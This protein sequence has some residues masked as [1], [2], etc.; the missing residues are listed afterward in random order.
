MNDLLHLAAADLCAWL[1]RVLPTLGPDWWTRYVFEQLTFAQQ[2]TATERRISRLEE[3]D[4]AAMLRVF[5]QNWYD[6]SSRENLPRDARN[7]LKELQ[8]VRNRVAHAPSA[9]FAPGDLYRD[10]DTLARVLQ[11]IGA[12][13][14]S[15]N[16]VEE[17]RAEVA[18]RL[19]P[20]HAGAL[21]GAPSSV[22]TTQVQ[23][24][25]GAAAT[26]AVAPATQ[27]SA[28]QMVSLRSD[29]TVIVPVLEVIPG[30]PNRYRV[31]EGQ[32]R[33]TYYEAQLVAVNED[34]PDHKPFTAAELSTLLTSMQLSSPTA[35]ALY[36]L[37]A[38]R[39]RFV[40]YQY[41]PVFKLIRA[42]RPR[43][44][45][46]DEVGVGKTIEAGLML[47]ELQ[48]R[49][50]I[51]SVLIICPKAL[52][53]E[54]KWEL[55]MKR[56][57]EHFTP[58]DSV[59]F[60]HCIDETHRDGAWPLQYERAILPF[61]LIDAET[62]LGDGRRR[63]G[64]TQLEEPPR[65]D[66]VIVDEAHHIR[67]SET[68]LHQAVRFFADNAEAVIFL[69][70]T[71][72]QLGRSDL[73]TVLNVLRP[74]LIIDPASFEQ[75]AAPNPHINAG[76]LACRRAGPDWA[77][78]VRQ[79]LLAVVATT[80]GRDVLAVNPGFQQIYDAL[81]GPEG[82]ALSR[83]KAIH[84]LEEL[85]T[86][87]A[88]INRTRRRDIGEFTTRKPETVSRD[89]TPTQQQLHD[90]LLSVIARILN[91]LHGSQNV[92]F[93]MTTI[94][95]QAASSLYGLAPALEDMLSGKLD[96]LETEIALDDEIDSIDADELASIR[97]DIQGLIRQA[98]A[99]DP[100][101]PKAD[102]FTMI[103]GEKLQMPKNKVL[104]FSTFR[105]TL[106]YLSRKLEDAGVRYALVQ[107]DIDD[108]ERSERRRRF[109]LPKVDP[110]AI[111]VLLSSE[112]GCEG[113]DFQF[114]D[115]LINYD[116]PW[117]PMRIEQRIGRIDRYGQ[118]SESIRIY[119][120]IT[121]GTIDADIYNRCLLRI[122]VFHAALGG[123]EEILGAV[124]QDLSKVA[125]SYALNEP[126]RQE[127]LQ[128]LADNH[129]R[130]L[131]EE[132][133]LDE[134]QGELFGLN[135]EAASW[136]EKLSAA[137]SYWLEPPAI[138]A[139][140]SSYL[141]KR[142]G[143]GQEYL[144]GEK[145]LKTLR[146]NQEARSALLEDFRRLPKT[147]DPNSRLWERWLRGAA[148]MLSVSFDQDMAIDHPEAM[149]VT[150]HHPLVRQAAGYLSESSTVSVQLCAL[151]ERIAPGAYP[152]AVYRW[153]KLGV[154]ADEELVP[155]TLDPMVTEGLFELLQSS[156]DAP[157]LRVISA[158]A[159]D[160]L[161]AAHH[162]RWLE[163]TAS[164]AEENRQLVNARRQSLQASHQAREA[165]LTDQLNNATNE[166]I[167][168]MKE[169][170]RSRMRADYA[171]RL[172]TLERAAE[173]GDIRA[174]LVVVGVIKVK[175]GSSAS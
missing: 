45:V 167:R 86:F 94:S 37:N 53:A 121:P 128:Q 95:R 171:G 159:V 36:S 160:E 74:D 118:E 27:F 39:V 151:S 8:S 154:K 59:T 19:S 120:V 140:V 5:D 62:L 131:E 109:K 35:S 135:I 143:K 168:R 1:G 11:V 28:G 31:F 133:K 76:I 32:R 49:H 106:R 34:G 88:M 12:G 136:D 99:L 113:L 7:W 52:V 96:R 29:P 79:S 15:L 57:G 23:T 110:N 60:R 145:P 149:L 116:L 161:D 44:L 119:N 172:T 81:S 33:V 70:A 13:A 97:T 83:V 51:K 48:A 169:A 114:C 61:S 100:E 21:A 20:V 98:K 150:L 163:V 103:I 175:N 124:S 72:I 77:E 25:G 68:Y 142:L 3:L 125:E 162:A 63:K 78:E 17:F 10:A 91:R 146:L 84:A 47:K 108:G 147:S 93:M 89:F 14:E 138:A 66:L 85:Y 157:D 54:R 174:E 123:S 82:E 107:G 130:R 43:L 156:M 38:G 132:R 166:R 152:F 50:D 2:R 42:D 148:P 141:T 137:R 41:R 165:L 153:T 80:W 73:F 4:L 112:V 127:R 117:N 139:A 46:A 158:S 104:V 71:P 65:F 144:L 164:H 122:G 87:S 16:R 129:V 126:Q 30:A 134:Q 56:F 55:E 40:P 18:S 64:L 90:D 75:M 115:C 102:A 105:H 101:D 67:N 69:S 155:I 58:L 24:D 170:E 111:D 26:M 173:T 6:I 92:R 9:G 22:S